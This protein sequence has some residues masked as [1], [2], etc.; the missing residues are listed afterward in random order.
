MQGVAKAVLVAIIVSICFL[1]FLNFALFFPWYSTLVIETFNLSQ[2]AA[3][4]NYVKQSYYENALENL[5]ER[6]IYKDK[7][8]KIEIE[9]MNSDYRE[10]VGFDDE[11]IYTNEDYGYSDW[12]KP[13]RQRGEPITVTIKAVYPF[14]VTLWGKKYEREFPVEFSLQTIGLKHYKDLDYYD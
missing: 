13:Y 7:S 6:P 12:D 9:I 11:S 1:L 5:K 3:K 14:T 8:D 10:A 2:I 4:D